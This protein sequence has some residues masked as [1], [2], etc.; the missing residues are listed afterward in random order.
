MHTYT[1]NIPSLSAI[2]IACCI[3]FIHAEQNIEIIPEIISAPQELQF[4][5]KTNDSYIKDDEIKKLLAANEV[6]N[7]ELAAVRLR[8]EIIKQETQ[9]VHNEL[10]QMRNAMRENQ[11]SI[12]NILNDL[13][14]TKKDLANSMITNEI[15]RSTLAEGYKNTKEP[16]KEGDLVPITPDIIPAR[17]LNLNRLTVKNV[18]NGQCQ[19]VVVVNVLVSEN[20]E[21]LDAKL[22]QGLF[23]QGELIDKANAICI[24][25]AKQIVFDPAQTADSRIRVRVWQ[26]VGII[27][28]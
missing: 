1:F 15:L 12:D 16:I 4:Q 24:E 17:P 26:G 13:Q 19:G 11:N 18:Y 14:N 22:L 28:N 5:Q 23:G 25:Q 20:G 8:S 21:T 2:L 9:V 3:T 27:L 7:E 10:E 6:L